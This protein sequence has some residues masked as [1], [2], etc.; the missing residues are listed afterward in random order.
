MLSVGYG[1]GA[2][3]DRFVGAGVGLAAGLVGAG[4]GVAAIFVGAGVEVDETVGAGVG[5]GCVGV[6]ATGAYCCTTSLGFP[7][8]ATASSAAGKRM[9]LIFMLGQVVG[10]ESVA[11]F[12]WVGCHWRGNLRSESGAARA[13]SSG[14]ALGNGSAN[15]SAVSST[16]ARTP[17]QLAVR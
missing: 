9:A 7:A 4:V 8:A 2:F 6:V 16:T 3:G 5:C 14:P 17:K 12:V 13:C 11:A 10:Y 1:V 15:V